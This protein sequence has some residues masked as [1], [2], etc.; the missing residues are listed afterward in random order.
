A[1]DEEELK[2]LESIGVQ[3][4]REGNDYKWI[5]L[6]SHTRPRVLRGMEDFGTEILKR[7][8]KACQD[9]GVEFLT[10]TQ[11]YR[12]VKDSQGRPRVALAIRKEA[13]GQAIQ[14]RFS[15]IVLATGGFGNLF[16]Y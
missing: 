7:M 4:Q 5:K 2:F 8:V 16:S 14:I 1:D 3:F 6:P 15:S 11:V 10:H 13:E 12:V 9:A